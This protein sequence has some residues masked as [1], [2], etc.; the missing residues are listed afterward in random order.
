MNVS[1]LRKYWSSGCWCMNNGGACCVVKH[2]LDSSLNWQ[3]SRCTSSNF[4]ALLWHSISESRTAL[5]SGP[6]AASSSFRFVFRLCF[7]VLKYDMRL[8]LYSVHWWFILTYCMHSISSEYSVVACLIV[9]ISDVIASTSSVVYL[10]KPGFSD[11]ICWSFM[12]RS[13]SSSQSPRCF[14]TLLSKTSR[15]VSMFASVIFSDK[16]LKNFSKF[17]L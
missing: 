9:A 16:K 7:V 3:F 6:A 12:F 17:S 5:W 13:S 11:S 8:I 1:H 4:L 15:S 2:L 10:S 14:N